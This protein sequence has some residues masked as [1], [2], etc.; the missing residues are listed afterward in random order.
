MHVYHVE[1]KVSGSR[2]ILAGPKEEPGKGTVIAVAETFFGVQD[3]PYARSV[4]QK[5]ITLKQSLLLLDVKVLVNHAGL[6][7]VRF[8]YF[9]EWAQGY[10]TTSINDCLG[11][12]TMRCPEI[13]CVAA[14]GDELV[15]KLVSDE[16]ALKYL[17]FLL[18]SYV[19]VK[20]R[21]KWCPSPDCDNAVEFVDAKALQFIQEITKNADSVQEKVLA[22]ILT[23]NTHTEFLG[24]Y[25]L[26]G[27][28]DRNTFKSK[29][30]M[31]TYEDLQ[32]DILRIANGD[33]SPILSSHPISEFLTSLV[34]GGYVMF[35]DAVCN[36]R[37]SG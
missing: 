33:R 3:Q 12:L 6:V 29:I 2:R 26:G 16:E 21:I 4:Y 8:I 32:P 28:I 18:R 14:V 11:C 5:S 25:K 24:R 19:E 30:P 34:T 20:K 36:L 35:V 31:I 23:Q 10:I 15:N 1:N 7:I 13:K 17:R 9:L 27:A 37:V 22:Q